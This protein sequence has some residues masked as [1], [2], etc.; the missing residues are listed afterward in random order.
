MTRPWG[1]RSVQ[2]RSILLLG[3][4]A[5]A[6]YGLPWWQV[7]RMVTAVAAVLLTAGFL[8]QSLQHVRLAVRVRAVLTARFFELGLTAVALALLVSKLVVWLQQIADPATR[9]ALDPVYRQYAGAFIVAAGL[10]AV[11]GDVGVRHALHRLDLRP[12]QTVA[13]GFASAILGGTVLLSLPLAVVRLEDVSLLDA[14]FTAASAVTVTGLIVYDP[15]TTLTLFGQAVVLA[16]IQVGGIGTMAASASLVVL[17]GRRLRLERAAAL[18]EA[19]DLET[20]GRVRGQLRTIVT[21]TLGAE[22]GGALALYV[23]WRDRAEVEAPLFAAVFHA[24]SAFCNAGFST[25]A[26]NLLTFREDLAIT[27]VIAL[28]VIV[29]GLGFPVLGSLA[30]ARPRWGAARPLLSLH[31]RLALL[32]SGLLLAGGTLAFVVLEWPGTLAPLSA[33]A[34]LA[35]A[36]FLAVTA[37][38]AGFNTVDT[39]ALAPATLWLLMVLMFVG[40]SPG[41]TAGGIKTTT[42]AT[43]VVALWATIRGRPRAEAFRRTLPDEQVAKALAVVGVSLALVAGAVIVL[44]ATQD[45]DPLGLIFE[46]V[47]AFGTVGLSTGATAALNA[48]GKAVIILLM[49]VGRIGPLT[50]GFALTARRGRHLVTYPAEKVMI[51]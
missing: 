1:I 10:R 5:A 47:S 25:F 16:L 9:S 51:G 27:A 48:W 35:A 36:G 11:A 28:L 40:G 22:V 39:A 31:A 32:T 8:A 38:T 20:V 19:M 14:L 24:V 50:L 2:Q 21:F 17:A 6:E 45:S 13:F 33:P 26:T 34:R 18:Q 3:V 29:G 7:G 23:L 41:S 12:A 15:G 44:L 42:A 30:L 46:A 4:I 49:F 37:R 43:T